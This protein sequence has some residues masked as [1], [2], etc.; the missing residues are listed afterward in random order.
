MM[1]PSPLQGGIIASATGAISRIVG[2]VLPVH[3]STIRLF[4]HILAA[5]VWVGGQVVLAAIVPL[6]RRLG[7]R[8]ATRAIARRFQIVAWPAF[9]VLLVT[10]TWNL[11]AVHVG[12]QSG[13]YLTTLIGKLLLVAASGVGALGHVL[14]APRRP[15]VGGILAAGSLL[16][17][18]AALFFGVLLRSG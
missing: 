13:R 8:D 12:D 10:G 1:P 11:F 6:A 16:S 7:G 2:A 15:A 14:V 3:A 9:A 17:A 18:V 5:T 4:L